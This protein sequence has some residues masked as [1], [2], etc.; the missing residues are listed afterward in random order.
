MTIGYTT[1]VY[2]LFHI[3]HLNLL[4]NAK[5]MCDKL[6]VGVTVDELVAYKGKQSMIPFEDRIEIVRSCKYVDAAV[7]QYDM[8]KLEACKKLGASFLFVGDDWYGTE[9]WQNYEKEFEEAGI[10]IIYFPYTKGVSSTKI[11]EA[12]NAVR[13]HNLED[14]K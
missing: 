9:K 1:G 8:N 4:K 11:N 7:P 5:G 3:G 2:D 6:I 14:V 10:K 12:L 13:K